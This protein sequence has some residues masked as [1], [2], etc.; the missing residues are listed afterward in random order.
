MYEKGLEL[1][2]NGG[3]KFTISIN[4]RSGTVLWELVC[5]VQ[6]TRNHCFSLLSADNMM[7]ADQLH[8]HYSGAVTLDYLHRKHKQTVLDT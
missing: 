6:R 8:T 2:H 5:T 7:R 4:E 1:G 3:I